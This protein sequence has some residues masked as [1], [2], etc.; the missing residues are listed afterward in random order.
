[1]L[2]REPGLYRIRRVGETAL[3]YVGQTGREI[4]E[5]V[6]ALRTIA[7][8]EMPYRD[9]HTAAPAFWAVLRADPCTFEV[10][11][12]PVEGDGSWRKSLEAVAIALYRQQ[13]G[14]S[15]RLNFGRMPAGYRMSSGNTKKLVAAGKRFR[16]G[17][18]TAANTSHL[19]GVSPVGGLDGNPQDGRWCGHVWS[20]W[21]PLSEY[22]FATGRGLYRI[23]SQAHDGLLYIGE[24]NIAARLGSHLRRSRVGSSSPTAQE[25]IFV[26]AVQPEFGYVAGEWEPHQRL[27]L[28]TDLIAAHVLRHGRPPPAQ[29]I[30]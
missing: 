14:C 24:G 17:R 27:E 11:C 23:R 26:G 13:T 1:V 5:R 6:R 19:P 18:T 21:Q 30:G 29:F 20:R 12:L 3:A 9:P 28:E 7:D 2:P 22:S 10:S 25:S 4:R 16:G 8:A 15:P